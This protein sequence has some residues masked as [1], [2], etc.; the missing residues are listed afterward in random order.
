M[1]GNDGSGPPNFTMRCHNGDHEEADLIDINDLQQFLATADFLSN[2]RMP[3]LIS[4]MQAAATEVLK[5]RDFV[6][7]TIQGA[8]RVRARVVT[9]IAELRAYFESLSE[10]PKE[11]EYWKKKEKKKKN[12][13]EEEDWMKK[14]KN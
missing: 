8:V 1:Q 6:L 5:G 3:S 13:S 2:Y 9:S 10:S 7:S 11:E 14:N 4:N 12:Q